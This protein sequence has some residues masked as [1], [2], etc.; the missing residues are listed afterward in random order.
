MFTIEIATQLLNIAFNEYPSLKDEE[1]NIK[2]GKEFEVELTAFDNIISIVKE[3]PR[4]DFK[5]WMDRYLESEFDLDPNV[6]MFYNFTEV[7]S[8][9]HEVGH[10]YY[11]DVTSDYNLYLAK[12]YN[13]Y[14]QAWREYRNM[15]AERLADEFAA[16][17]IKNQTIKI[18]AL[19]NEISEEEA[20]EEFNFWSE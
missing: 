6:Y 14:S 13:S 2:Y 7:Y 1:I 8:F 3:L 15:K 12:T 5:S 4:D 20:Q 9:L 10:I 19:M 18:W 17:I 11:K 16:I